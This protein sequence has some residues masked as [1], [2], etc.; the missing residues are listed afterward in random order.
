VATL[1]ERMLHSDAFAWYM[2]KDPVLRSTVVAIT[3]LDSSPD[4]E[5][6][7]FRVDRLS[8][9][10]PHLRM[11]VQSPP[12]RIGP[13]R[14]TVDETF[15]LDYHLRRARIPQPRRWEQVLEFA[16]VAAMADFDRSR[17][18]WEFTLLE[19]LAGGGAAFV[20]K[21]HHS[22]SDG[23]GGVQ[24]AALV[25]DLTP[26]AAQPADL[27]DVPTGRRMSGIAVAAHALED[28]T[29]EAAGTLGRVVRYVPKGMV[30]AAL[31]PIRSAKTVAQTTAS[32]GR[33]VAPVSH[34]ESP[35]LGERQMTRRLATVD[36]PFDALHDAAAAAGCHLNDAYVSAVTE[37]MRRYHEKLGKPL[38]QVRVTVPVSLR[39]S[40]DGLGG[41][42]ITLIRIKVPNGPMPFA[43]RI[44]AVGAVMQRW[45]AEPALDHAQGIAQG[46]NLLPRAYLGG[47]FKRVELLASDVPGLS[48]EVWLAGAK[49][50]GYYGFGPTIGAAMNCTLMSYA[51][52]C[53]VGVN[54]DTGAVENPDLLLDCL[55]QSFHDVCAIEPS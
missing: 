44:R 33:F 23:I 17:P 54:I 29:K 46:L 50:T 49:V 30:R 35:L 36:V 15:D 3:R 8:R 10:V 22:L 43:E 42:R 48:N 11:R 47:V 19:G 40:N 16:R 2:E 6:L 32:V 20:A 9:M 14:W 55:R 39:K 41:N 52:T 25:V 18:L 38:P 37:A 53:N 51:G 5:R 7:R 4:W 1:E 45:R 21:L 26:D 28:E 24:L 12:L 31:Y 27:P 34:Q 13:P